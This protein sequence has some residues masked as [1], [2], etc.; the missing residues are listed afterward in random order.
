[1]KGDLFKNLKEMSEILDRLFGFWWLEAGTCLGIYRDNKLI[2]W[3]KDID[4]GILAEDISTKEMLFFLFDIALYEDFRIYH[5]F[6]YL[7]NGF[8]V[9][10]VKRGIKVD[11]FWFY[12]DGDIRW[13]SAWKNGGKNGLEDQLKYEY[14]AEVIEERKKIEFKGEEFYLPKNTERY[15]KIKYGKDWKKPKKKWNWAT[16]PKNLVT[17]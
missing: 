11:L 3:D 12:K 6:G 1:M 8:E 16:S 17:K 15:L 7:D 13:H 9:S 4:F 14:P 5:T 10:F 2:P